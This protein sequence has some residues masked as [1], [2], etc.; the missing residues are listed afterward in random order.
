M[1]FRHPKYYAELRK[2]RRKL[3]SAQARGGKPTSPEPRAQAASQNAQAPES[4]SQ[5][6]SA[7]AHAPGRKQQG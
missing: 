7:Q 3:T 1:E 4:S 5:G 6:T 2:E